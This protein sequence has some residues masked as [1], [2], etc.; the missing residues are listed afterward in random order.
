MYKRLSQNISE[1]NNFA[2]KITVIRSL[3]DDVINHDQAKQ[4]CE[5]MSFLIIFQLFKLAT[6]IHKTVLG[7]ITRKNK[8][9]KTETKSIESKV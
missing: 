8:N 6:L 4:F 7:N 2:E 5:L 1:I 9:D 3:D